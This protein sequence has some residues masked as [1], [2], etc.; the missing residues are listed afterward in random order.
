M[1]VKSYTTLLT[2]FADNEVRAI[3]ASD[4]RDLL[5][6]W[7]GTYCYASATSAVAEGDVSWGGYVWSAATGMGFD[8]HAENGPFTVNLTDGGC[9]ISLSSDEGEGTYLVVFTMALKITSG[10]PAIGVP[11]VY[12]RFGVNTPWF[13]S[14]S[15][16]ATYAL[17]HVWTALMQ[18]EVGTTY[19]LETRCA[20]DSYS[21]GG[22]VWS[23]QLL[24]IRV[25]KL[26]DE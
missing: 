12:F 1:G 24:L 4:L 8:I 19:T 25:G 13:V 17:A 7:P 10:S 9:A 23:P 22:A 5:D 16:N 3:T 20:S 15:N 26:E 2:A 18:L 21:G 14:H 6:S 11:Q